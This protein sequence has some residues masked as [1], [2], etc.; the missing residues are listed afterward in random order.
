MDLK[1]TNKSVVVLAAS[2]GLGLAAALSLAAEGCKVAVCARNENR[3]K[4]AADEISQKTGAEVFYQSVD[5]SKKED[6]QSFI[7]TVAEKWA[8]IDILVTNAG[9]PPVKTFVE[10]SDEEWHYWYD[11]TYMS[12]VR[13]IKAALPYMLKKR[14]GRIINITSISVKAPVEGLVYSNALRLAVVG[15]AKT[16]SME[17]GRENI[18]VN[19]VAPGYH[20]TDALERIVKKKV[21]QGVD[22]QVVINQMAEKTALGRIGM[23]D[24]LAGLITF[25]ASDRAAYISGTTIQVD[26]G[27]YR[28]I[29]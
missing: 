26:G 8:G 27:M 7:E 4:K 23:P 16:L 13:S 12:V 19:N 10:T 5:V 25:L 17:L 2:K 11:V 28:G 18:T 29:L 20:L 24:D 1:L 6:L 9:G 14:W 21:E 15:L 3:L 22:R